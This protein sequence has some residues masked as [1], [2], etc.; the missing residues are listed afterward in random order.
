MKAAGP[1]R[2]T[3]C[4]GPLRG[5]GS[6]HSGCAAEVDRELRATYGDGAPQLH[7]D[8]GSVRI[9]STRLPHPAPAPLVILIDSREQDRWVFPTFVGREKRPVQTK[10]GGLPTGDYTTEPLLGLA[11]IERKSPGDFMSTI[12]HDRERWDR[13]VARFGQLER[14]CIVVEGERSECADVAP[15]VRWE[16]VEGTI[17]S[18]D[19]KHRVAVHF[20]QGRAQ[21]AW[22]AAS[23]LRRAEAELLPR[24]P[25]AVRLRDAFRSCVARSGVSR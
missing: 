18:L 2:C 21:A 10:D 20:K 25:P 15:G 9:P 8:R 14:V 16:S 6:I 24:I 3:R 22:F 23:W 4:G 11:V 7:F 19:V 5:P 1:E 13:E 17:A 12:T